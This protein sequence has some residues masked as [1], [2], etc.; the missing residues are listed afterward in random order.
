MRY[1]GTTLFRSN[2]GRARAQRIA[3]IVKS[4]E[5]QKLSTSDVYWDQI[6][7]IEPD[8]EQAVYD[9]TVNT[10]HNFVANDIIVHNSLEQDADIVMFIY[11]DELYNENTETPNIADIMIA[12]HRSGPTGNIQ[13]FF[14]KRLTQFLDAATHVAP[15]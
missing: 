3:E 7:S 10:H 15:G 14:N 2:I 12:K 8:G 1:C 4:E 5:L 9:L 6:V 11:R 13:L